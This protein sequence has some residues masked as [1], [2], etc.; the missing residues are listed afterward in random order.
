MPKE[1]KTGWYPFDKK[2]LTGS[3]QLKR[4]KPVSIEMPIS[5]CIW[6]GKEIVIFA[7]GGG[8]MKSG[9]QNGM[10]LSRVEKCEDQS[11]LLQPY[12]NFFT[13]TRVIN[14]LVLHPKYP[15]QVLAALGDG[16]VGVFELEEVSSGVGPSC[17]EI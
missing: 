7:G 3:R 17:V 13:G 15:L 14:D 12:G 5:S 11:L 1:Q 6:C 9:I 16:T 10:V 4:G 8:K 2:T